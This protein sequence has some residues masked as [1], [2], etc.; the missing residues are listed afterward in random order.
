MRGFRLATRYQEG[1]SRVSLIGELRARPGLGPPG[2]DPHA[3][4]VHELA[5]PDPDQLAALDLD[6]AY[7][8]HARAQLLGGALG[9]RFDA[10][11][12]AALV[13]H[14]DRRDLLD[15]ERDFLV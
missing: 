13:D 14:R 15:R 12:I 3:R 7:A 2:P 4:P 1:L 10:E 9:H 5:R 11:I 8:L 6:L